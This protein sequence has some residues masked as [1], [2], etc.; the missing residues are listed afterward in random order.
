MELLNYARR[1]K[2]KPATNATRRYTQP[3]T[4]RHS[5]GRVERTWFIESSAGF[6]LEDVTCVKCKK[7]MRSNALLNWR[8]FCV[9]Q[10]MLHFEV[11]KRNIDYLA[12]PP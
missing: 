11:M 6:E 2:I 8:C 10:A 5:A 7:M 9:Q 1:C 12:D 4:T 3:I